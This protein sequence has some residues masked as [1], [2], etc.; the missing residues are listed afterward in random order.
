MSTETT[1]S[2]PVGLLA[3]LQDSVCEPHPEECNS[4]DHTP[5]PKV[6]GLSQGV[7]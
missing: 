2:Q 1:C 7:F 4:S 3:P 6:Q 5:P